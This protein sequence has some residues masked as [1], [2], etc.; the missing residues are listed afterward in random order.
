MLSIIQYVDKDG[1]VEYVDKLGNITLK[2]SEAI[3]IPTN[4]AIAAC[5]HWNERL[6]L[7]GQYKIVRVPYVG[8]YGL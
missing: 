8:K 2:E 3:R 4:I 5:L 6:L 7:S 1:V